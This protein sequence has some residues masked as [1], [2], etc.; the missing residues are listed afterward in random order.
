[1]VN[2]RGANNQEWKNGSGERE[3][4]QELIW[5]AANHSVWPNNQLNYENIP[6]KAAINQARCKEPN[7]HSNRK[8]GNNV[9][10]FFLSVMSLLNLQRYRKSCEAFYINFTVKLNSYL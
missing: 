9:A 7:N 4:Q 5:L 10:H 3:V 2:K 6:I 8:K 1:M